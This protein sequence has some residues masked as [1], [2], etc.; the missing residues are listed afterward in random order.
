MYSILKLK[1]PKLAP[2]YVTARSYKHYVPERFV[3]YLW[4]IPRFENAL[5]DDV[6]D[7]LEHFDVNFSTVL[8]RHAPVK[9]MKIRYR[10]CLFVDKETID[11]MSEREK[12]HRLAR[13]TQLPS[14]WNDFYLLRNVIKKKLRDA[15][16]VHIQREISKNYDHKNSL[17]KTIKKCIPRKEV[18]Q[19]IYSKDLGSLTNKF[20][21]FFTS[22]GPN[23]LKLSKSVV[24][25][26]N[27]PVL[28]HS[29]AV[30]YDND[31]V[32]FHFHPVSCN[33]VRKVVQS[34]PLNKAPGSDKISMRVIKDALP[35]RK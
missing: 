27:L 31:D 30:G 16:K 34:F 14:D 35:C 20:N 28:L 22:V 23:V 29:T 11:L 32:V 15:E 17:W 7:K 26:H 1:L 8:D 13:I 4:Q 9:T 21:A 24:A 25:D 3:N 18:S 12:L 2:I 33:E 5:I 10:Q 6:N 19:P